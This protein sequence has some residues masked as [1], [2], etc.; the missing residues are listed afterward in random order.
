MAVKQVA[1]YVERVQKRFPIL[2]KSEI[3]KILTF[4][5]KRYA[6]VNM[7]HCDVNVQN[8]LDETLS[9]ICGLLVRDGLKHFF[10][11]H[12][13]WRMKERALFRF[14]KKPWDNYYYIGLSEE[15]HQEII[16]QKSSTKKFKKIYLT[17]LEGELHHLRW[18]KRIWRVPYPLDCGWKFFMEELKTDKAEYVGTNDYGKYHTYL[19]KRDEDGSASSSD[20]QSDVH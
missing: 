20:G 9:T 17:K 18:V 13:K 11:W 10:I 4:G 1:D 5:M 3:N 2:S 7:W 6:Y 8:R 19:L 16:K 12:L 14:R 15:D